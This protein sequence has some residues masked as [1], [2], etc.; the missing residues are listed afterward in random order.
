MGAYALRHTALRM[1]ECPFRDRKVAAITALSNE[2]E[3]VL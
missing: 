1:Q 2:Q 3:G